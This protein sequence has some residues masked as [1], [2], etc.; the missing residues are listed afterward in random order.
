MGEDFS[1]SFGSVGGTEES[2][3]L[4]LKGDYSRAM[5]LRGRL[6]KSWVR[7]VSRQPL[8]LVIK[9]GLHVLVVA[10]VTL[11][12]LDH[13]WSFAVVGTSVKRIGVHTNI[14]GSSGIC[15]AVEKIRDVLNSNEDLVSS[16]RE[17]MDLQVTFKGSELVC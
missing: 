10:D 1:L 16:L 8:E 14:E 15:W 13:G 5:I 12:D 11:N 2:D 17:L 9:H 4:G 3:S 7:T 6:I